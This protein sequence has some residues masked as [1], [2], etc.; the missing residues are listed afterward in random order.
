M[1][2]LFSQLMRFD[3]RWQRDAPMY[4]LMFAEVRAIRDDGYELSWLSGAMTEPSAPARV[5]T[6][7]A[8]KRRGAFFTPEVGDEVVVGFEMGNLDRPVILGAL[9]SDQD[10]PPPQADTSPT[11]NIRT[12]V[13]RSGHEITFDDSPDGKIT[14]KTQG[15]MEITLQ[16]TPQKI[17]ITTTGNIA[18]SRLELD[19]VAWNH[20]HATGTGPSGPPISL[21]PV[22]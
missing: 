8:G 9:W 2:K 17:T 4:G 13:S 6:L 20:Q 11:N 1:T 10:E 22:P 5:A 16:D 14:I 18:T 12:I 15:G 7:M 19:G 3:E 21:V